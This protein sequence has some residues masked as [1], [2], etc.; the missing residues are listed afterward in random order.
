ML[1]FPLFAFLANSLGLHE[2][3]IKLPMTI[4]VI[5]NPPC[6]N[7]N[8]TVLYYGLEKIST[9]YVF[10]IT[11]MIR[12]MCGRPLEDG[13]AWERR[14]IM[15]PQS[16]LPPSWS[17]W[18]QLLMS[19]TATEIPFIY[20]F[21]GNCAA[22][23]P[24]STFI[25]LWAI[26]IFPGSVFIFPPAEKAD[27]SWEY[28]IRSQT[29]ECG[30]WAWVPDIPFLGIFVSN[31]RHFVF[32]VWSRLY[33]FL[34]QVGLLMWFILIRFISHASHI[35][36]S[37]SAGH[38]Q[39]LNLILLFHTAKKVSYFPVTGRDVTNQTLPGQE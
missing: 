6:F 33:K 23:A 26:Y 31:F 7:M 29:Y 15:R 11:N 25:C 2:F 3:Q 1:F 39:E 12:N 8:P 28:I 21:P 20:S 9:G 5:Y 18:G 19:C 32:A 38:M 17:C 13:E 35:N 27:P 16:L 10:Q 36:L 30:N 4:I 22:S 34:K 24:I 14:M 37:R